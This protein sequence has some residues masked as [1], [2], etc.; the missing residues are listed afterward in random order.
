MRKAIV[1]LL[2]ITA[3]DMIKAEM[4]LD[5]PYIVTCYGPYEADDTQEEEGD[6]ETEDSDAVGRDVEEAT[7]VE[8]SLDV[9]T[10]EEWLQTAVQDIAY[11]L[12]A[13]KFNDFDRRYHEDENTAPRVSSLTAGYYRVTQKKRELLKNPTKIEEIQEKKIIDRNL[14]IKTCLLRDS[15]PNYQCLKITS[16]RC[17]MRRSRILQ[18]MQ[19]TQGDTKERELLKCVVAVKECTRGGGRHLQDVT[20][21]H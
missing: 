2:L 8:E 3:I 6:M 17:R 20:F 16:C 1:L 7:V 11:Y 13:H 14:T 21:K 18:S 19:H 15:N 5:T 4:S 9:T 12:R 10:D